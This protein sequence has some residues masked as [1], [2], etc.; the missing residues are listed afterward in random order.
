MFWMTDYIREIKKQFRDVY[1]F[2]P[3]KIESGEPCFDSIPDGIYPMKING[4]KDWVEI[5][6][7]GIHCCNFN[8]PKP[9][10]KE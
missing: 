10:K 3:S 5:K 9:S 7:S 1:K 8:K 2:K 6:D 4:R